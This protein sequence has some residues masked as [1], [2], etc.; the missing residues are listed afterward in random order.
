[1]AAEPSQFMFKHKDLLVALIKAQNLHDGLW[2]LAINFGFAAANV[3]PN[4]DDVNPTALATVTAIG[5]QRVD[6]MSSPGI[7]VNAAEVNPA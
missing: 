3:G 7:T 4:S 6:A 2:Q 5:L 1:M